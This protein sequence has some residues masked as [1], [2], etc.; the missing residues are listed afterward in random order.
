MRKFYIICLLIFCLPAGFSYAQVTKKSAYHI[1][2]I[3][4]VFKDNSS[5]ESETILLNIAS[6]RG[7]YFH[8]DVIALDAR[9]IQKFYFN[10]GFL[11]AVVDTS[12]IYDNEDKEAEVIFTVTENSLYE[13]AGI[14]YSG[15]D[16]VMSIC[17]NE[18]YKKGAGLKKGEPYEKTKID[19]EVIRILNVLK[20]YGYAMAEKGTVEVENRMSYKNAM[21]EQIFVR[22]SFKPGGLYRFGKVKVVIKD[23]KYGLTEGDFKKHFKFREG[24]MFDQDKLNK[25]ADLI[26]ADPLIE[27]SKFEAVP[28]PGNTLNYTLTVKLRYR[29]E[30]KPLLLAYDINNLLYGGGGFGYADRHFLGGGGR[31]F[32]GTIQSMYHSPDNHIHELEMDVTQPYLFGNENITGYLKLG[33]NYVVQ[34]FYSLVGVLEQ[35]TIGYKL[36]SHT[37]INN[38]TFDWELSNLN[39]STRK[40][41]VEETEDGEAVIDP[42]NLNIFLSTYGFSLRHDGMNDLLYPTKG[43]YQYLEVKES[44]LLGT[45]V[46]K[47]FNSETYKYL[48]TQSVNKAFVDFSS[49]GT[50]V[51]GMKF[52]TGAI[53]DYGTNEVINLK[54]TAGGSSSNRGWPS[55]KL[56]IVAEKEIGGNFLFEGSFEH[57]LK[58]FT[59]MLGL[60]KDLGFVTFVDY[61]NVWSEPS[62]FRFDEIAVSIG[63]GIRY[64]TRVGAVRFDVGFKLYD[65]Q[66][67][68]VGG[69]HWLF[70]EGAHF[71]DKYTFQIGIGN[72]F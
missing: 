14:S 15:L 10:K 26:N 5:F 45:V 29:Y 71:R 37:Y 70:G 60:I 65:P 63:T 50:S 43:F 19:N 58:P 31:V 51:L 38:V 44:G 18:I 28:G 27:N 66:P 64:Y 46:E 12:I 59:G 41:I 7:G 30:L 8:P 42:F 36:P 56:G 54:F 67:G 17:K 11:K 55:R 2:D 6:A 21:Q 13:V 62:K 23:N 3:E 33:G 35:M 9:R 52:I 24:E 32:S 22:L 20:N 68:H 1:D 39:F 61:G 53:F 48:K 4:V 72:T 69:A 34:E 16:S 57:R 47:L 49:S 25:T 40:A